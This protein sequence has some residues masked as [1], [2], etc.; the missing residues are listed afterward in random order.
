MIDLTEKE[1]A[2]YRSG[3]AYHRSG[4]RA[5]LRF[6]AKLSWIVAFVCLIGGSGVAEAQ[7]VLVLKNGRQITVQSYREEGSMIKF[8]SMG[9]D[10][11]IGKDQVQSIRRA[12]EADRSAVP[13]PPVDRATPSTPPQLPSTVVKPAAARPSTPPLSSEDQIAK[14]RAE[15]EKLYQ[16]KIKELTEQLKEL[17]ERYSLITRGNKGSEPSFFTTEE[18]FRGHQEDLLSRLRDAQYKAQ[19]LPSGANATSPPFSLDAPP[20]YSERQKQLSELRTRIGEL[21]KNRER[22]IAE[23]K[24]K[25]FETGSLFLD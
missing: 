18:A 6:M 21:E 7:Y 16:D 17:R 14:D 22:L 24:A 19:G 13:S 12:G 23:M 2:E 4:H 1:T 9:G 10:I 3:A 11:A 20:A 5:I 15:E 8:S 25:K